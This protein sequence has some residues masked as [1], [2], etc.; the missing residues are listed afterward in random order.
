MQYAAGGGHG[1]GRRQL[2]FPPSRRGRGG[3]PGKT[4][5]KGV[6]TATVLREQFVKVDTAV[7][8]FPAA[9]PGRPS[10]AGIFPARL[11]KTGPGRGETVE[12]PCCFPVSALVFVH[13]PTVFLRW[14]GAT[15]KTRRRNLPRGIEGGSGRTTGGVVSVITLC[16]RGVE[17]FF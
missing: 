1:R 5:E 13:F 10:G 17:S 4:G 16:Q 15:G 2:F 11:G 7:R 8:R 9:P 12:L 6:E 3:L 14:P